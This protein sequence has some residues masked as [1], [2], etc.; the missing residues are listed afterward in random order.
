MVPYA[1]RKDVLPA[2][3]ALLTAQ[4]REGPGQAFE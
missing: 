2:S 1:N 3:M 4:D